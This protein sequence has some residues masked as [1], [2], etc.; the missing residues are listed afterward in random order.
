[1]SEFDILVI[2]GLA[3]LIFVI[4]LKRY[5]Y[6]KRMWNNGICEATGKKWEI[7]WHD[8]KG[9]FIYKSDEHYLTLEF[10]WAEVKEKKDDEKTKRK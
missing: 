9:N 6:E 10:V 8:Y 7:W 4:I 1:M 3:L 5:L 2:S